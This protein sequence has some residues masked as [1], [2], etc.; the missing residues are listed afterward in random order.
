MFYNP[1]LVTRGPDAL[2]ARASAF[3][4]WLNRRGLE[5]VWLMTGEKLIIGE[6]FRSGREDWPGRLEISAVGYFRGSEWCE[7]GVGVLNRGDGKRIRLE[8]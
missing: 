2:L 3:R 5:V 1:S 8:W 7:W 4:G 6:T